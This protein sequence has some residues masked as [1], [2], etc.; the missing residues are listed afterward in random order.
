MPNGAGD[1]AG[2]IRSA[3]KYR[4]D[5]R[6]KQSVVSFSKSEITALGNRLSAFGLFLLRTFRF[7]A[8]SPPLRERGPILFGTF[9]AQGSG[10]VI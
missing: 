9:F 1:L 8:P 2:A 6:T 5:E 3:T 7:L 4:S 10:C